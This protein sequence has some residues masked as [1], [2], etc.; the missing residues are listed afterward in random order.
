VEV[1]GKIELYR[2]TPEIVIDRADQIRKPR[3][4]LILLPIEVADFHIELT[5]LPSHHAAD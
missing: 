5:V 3:I 2:D 4:G 1:R